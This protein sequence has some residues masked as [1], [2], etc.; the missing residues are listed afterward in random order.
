MYRNMDIKSRWVMIQIFGMR[1]IRVL[2]LDSMTCV[3]LFAPI[4]VLYEMR[5]LALRSICDPFVSS[6][7]GLP[8]T[9]FPEPV[10]M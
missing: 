3:Y 4:L 7:N 5:W 10:I 1:V 8:V 9:V 6:I 2:H